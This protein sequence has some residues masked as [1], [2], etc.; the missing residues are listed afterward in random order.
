MTKLLTIFMLATLSACGQTESKQVSEKKSDLPTNN[1]W[2]TLEQSNYSIQYPSSWTPNENGQLGM[3][4]IIL[5]PK[6]SPQDKFSENVNLLIQDLTGENV[7]LNKYVEISENQIKTLATNLDFI[8]SKRIKS[9]TS[10]YHRLIYSADQGIFHLKY[11]QFYLV[12]KESVYVLTFTSEQN[13]FTD[14]KETGEKILNSFRL[15]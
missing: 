10:E 5:S 13:K 6:E 9:G 2:K 3:K 8:E 14:F 12:N 15:K 7:D 1:E 4:F 11:E